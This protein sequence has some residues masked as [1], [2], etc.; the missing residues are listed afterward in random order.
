MLGKK[1]RTERKPDS[2]TRPRWTTEKVKCPEGDHEARLLIELAPDGS[3]EVKG[4][5]CDNPEF[6]GL[7][8]WDCKWSCW[9]KMKA[10][11]K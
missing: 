4:I 6:A 9:E 2:E 7:D 1:K 8:N 10:K 3:G 11:K 5:S